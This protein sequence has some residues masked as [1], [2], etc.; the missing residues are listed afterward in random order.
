[1]FLLIKT[2]TIGGVGLYENEHCIFNNAMLLCLL[3]GRQQKAEKQRHT[4]HTGLRLFA[5]R[6]CQVGKP[7]HLILKGKLQ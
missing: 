6:I 7:D 1:M 5:R 3:R 2:D 4:A